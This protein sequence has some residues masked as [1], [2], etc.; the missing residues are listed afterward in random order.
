MSTTTLR[1]LGQKSARRAA[2]PGGLPSATVLH[3]LSAQ[4]TLADASGTIVY[5][6][7]SAE[8]LF[9]AVES[10][11]REV[12]PG[13][14]ARTLVGTSMHVFQ[15]VAPHPGG[16][17]PSLLAHRDAE[18]ELGARTLA[19]AVHPLDGPDGSRL[20]YAVEWTD[21]TRG[22]ALAR[23]QRDLAAALAAA[24]GNDMGV[25]V[26]TEDVHE[27]HLPACLAANTL[28]DTLD[29]LSRELQR[30][31]DE[32]ERGEIDAVLEVE[33]F[34][35]AFQPIARAVN[36]M[37][38]GHIA[39]KKQA[40]A[41]VRAFGNGDFDVAMPQLPGKKA[42]IN[43]IIE[44]VRGNL[45]ALITDVESLVQ[46][47]VAGELDTR[48]DVSAHHGGFRTIVAGVND[49]L[50]AIVGPLREV[51]A[52]LVAMEHGDLTRTATTPYRGQLEELRSATNSTVTRLGS[53]ITDVIGAAEQLGNAAAQ[54]SHAANTMAQAVTEQAAS[55]EQTTASIEQMSASIDQT[56]DNAQVTDEIAGKAA[57]EADEGG[58]AVLETVEAMKTIASK[59]AIVD[60]I[61][62]QTNM[63]ALNATI[64]AARAGE[65]GKGFA[66]VAT[67]VG[68]LAERS[69]VAAQE[70][71][72]LAAGSVA[73]AE[74]AGA[75]LGEIVPSIGRTSDLVQ[76]ITAACT[77]QS[78][79]AGQVSAAVAQINTITQQNAASSEELAATAAE[80]AAQT[81]SMLH[82]MHFFTVAEQARTTTAP[83]PAVT[84]PIPT[85]SL[86]GTTHPGTSS[87]YGSD[88][89]AAFDLDDA[90]FERF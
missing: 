30:V 31:S 18:I 24:A 57:R 33:A 8:R 20:G 23:V 10:D 13:F 51:S 2:T 28:I 64:E 43:D 36:D 37:V 12:V 3:G 77:E 53:T 48:A 9:A 82:Q 68:K 86:V 75:L 79:G 72:E 78:A 69:Q 35:E 87:L 7:P 71:G 14:E 22:A 59:I 74:R 73:T 50:D 63:L 61:A 52:V 5:A 88:S 58:T 44:Q 15:G 25:R 27:D 46:S 11:L 38:G 90:H 29:L 32:H 39:V 16:P 80:M 19:L 62:F 40:M 49:T 70:I 66:V 55:T 41:V 85:V 26:A 67:E 42:F 6:N 47:A 17:L 45:K 4:I 83:V 81:Q 34:S 56:S 21:A 60:E 76:E 84:V 1:R 65:H 89:A 54:I